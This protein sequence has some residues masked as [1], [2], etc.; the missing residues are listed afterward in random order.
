MKEKNQLLMILHMKQ[1]MKKLK[2]VKFQVLKLLKYL[3]SLKSLNILILIL[4]M[5]VKKKLQRLKVKLLILKVCYYLKL[6][7]L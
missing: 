3:K 4:F 2:K 5:N 1:N 7:P 6:R